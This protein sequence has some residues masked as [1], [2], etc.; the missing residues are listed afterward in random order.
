MFDKGSEF[1]QDLTPLLKYLYIK[2]VLTLVKNPQ[3]NAPVERVHQ[4]ILNIIFTKDLD[5]KVFGYIYPW[6]ETLASIAWEIRYS[7]HC[8]IMSTSGQDFFYQDS[9]G[10][11][12]VQDRLDI[13]V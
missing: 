8:N 1:K 7:Y 11:R 6:G 2:P 3:A 13:Y 9:P 12:L 10:H 4:V 5:K